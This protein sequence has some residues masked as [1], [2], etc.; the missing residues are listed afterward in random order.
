MS[1]G[2][3]AGFEWEP[4]S[5]AGTMDF[6]LPVDCTLGS[7]LAT[8]TGFS[9]AWD[10]AWLLSGSARGA[11][12]GKFRPPSGGNGIRKGEIVEPIAEVLFSA[13][14]GTVGRLRD[15][16]VGSATFLGSGEATLVIRPQQAA[17]W[18]DSIQAA[19]DA[20]RSCSIWCI[21]GPSK[22][23][24]FS[25]WTTRS[26]SY[27]FSRSRKGF[28]SR[29][30]SGR[31][32]CSALDA[33][34]LPAPKIT[35][36]G[37]CF[38]TMTPKQLAL[39]HRIRPVALEFVWEKPVQEPQISEL[40][41]YLMAVGF[42]VGRNL[43]PIGISLFSDESYQV[44]RCI[45]SASVLDISAAVVHASMPPVVVDEEGLAKL[46]PALE[47]QGDE[48]GLFDAIGKIWLAQSVPVEAAL[49]N[50]ASALECIMNAW[51]RSNKTKSGG[52]YLAD[53]DWSLLSKPSLDTLDAA[54]QGQPNAARM[55]RRAASANNFGVNERFERFFDEIGLPVGDVELKAIQARNKAAH[56]GGFTS[57]QM[58]GLVDTFRAYRV[59][60]SRVIL[61][62]LEWERDYIDYSTY[63][64]PS[65]DLG[66]PAGGPEGDGVAAKI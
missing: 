50:L 17:F 13:K 44:F 15:V 31:G 47:G 11:M 21:N 40:S 32:E 63:G 1:R 66:D 4:L 2:I 14:D 3:F 6:D 24:P 62:L 56:G 38:L 57:S 29:K 54:L 5:I 9:M 64:F 42:V 12:N 61:K 10:A 18:I 33:I 41:G 60:L 26:Q 52:K 45:Q 58:Q 28:I 37:V 46:I 34:Q 51:F 59:L 48:L 30:R 35:G 23:F 36:T 65:R 43:I 7:D 22:E 16:Y 49:P 25:L 39:D 27:E 55:V 8:F 53:R 19:L 20:T